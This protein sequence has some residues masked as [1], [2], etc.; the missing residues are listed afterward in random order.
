MRSI[1]IS[2]SLDDPLIK[3]QMYDLITH[4]WDEAILLYWLIYVEI[5]VIFDWYTHI[6][7][8]VTAT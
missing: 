8:K 3:E 4:G 5:R 1:S 2:L 7:I 6:D